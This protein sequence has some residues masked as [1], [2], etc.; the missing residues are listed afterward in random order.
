MTLPLLGLVNGPAWP[1]FTWLMGLM[2]WAGGKNPSPWPYPWAMPIWAL[3]S[4]A[5]EVGFM[6]YTWAFLTGLQLGF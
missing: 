1:I 4:W 3:A 2:G 6:G 5:S